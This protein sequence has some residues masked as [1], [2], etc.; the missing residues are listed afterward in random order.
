MLRVKSSR[1][2]Q[3]L[4]PGDY[5]HEID[6]VD[7]D[8]VRT[9]AESI[10]PE[11][12]SMA[13]CSTTSRL[14]ALDDD[15]ET[16]HRQNGENGHQHNGQNGQNKKDDGEQHR[17]DD[18]QTEDGNGP[19]SSSSRV[20][21]GEDLPHPMM[22]PSIEVQGQ[23]P[24]NTRRRSSPNTLIEPT[25]QAFHGNH[26]QVMTKKPHIERETAIDILY[27]NERGGFLCGIA[28]FSGRAL[29]GLDPPAWSKLTLHPRNMATRNADQ[30]PIKPMPT[31]RHRRLIFRLLKSQTLPGNGHGL[32][33]ASITRRASTKKA[34]NTRSISLKSSRG[35][36]AN[37][38][39]RSSDGVPGHASG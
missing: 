29:G 18:S 6:L 3:G 4:K 13:R 36:A 5:D 7:H 35:T 25:P 14:L 23:S 38:G 27:E 1:R 8:A 19:G 26:P 31:T 32:S 21:S 12:A 22:R 30:L 33:G 20:P 16:E 2:P 9:P 24:R 39:T 34:G 11:P 37:G 17:Q 15:E 28:L 10:T